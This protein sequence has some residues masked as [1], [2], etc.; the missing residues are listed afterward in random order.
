MD[1]K[2]SIVL[3]ALEK[4]AFAEKSGEINPPRD[5]LMQAITPDTGLFYNILAKASKTKR[6]LEIGTSAGYSTL[7]FADALKYNYGFKRATKVIT[8]I[9]SNP[10]KIGVATRNFRE[11]GVESMIEV[12][13]G[14]ALE[15]LTMLSKSDLNN[16]SNGIKFD[17]VFLDA[18]KENLIEYFNLVL[19]LVAVGGIIAADNVL[20]PVEYKEAIQDYL[21]YIRKIKR[22]Q[23]VTI[24]IGNGE[25]LSFKLS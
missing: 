6:V 16:K 8:T 23:S 13:N 20:Y 2:I 22:I 18:D 4:K 25:E 5:K 7:W 19:P 12:L 9:E 17:L 14:H 11:A 24:P 1:S 3:K 21:K 10:Y 15:R